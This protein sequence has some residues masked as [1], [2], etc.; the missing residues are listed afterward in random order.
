MQLAP[1]AG[2]SRRLHGQSPRRGQHF[3]GADLAAGGQSDDAVPGAGESA[4]KRGAV[5]AARA[6]IAVAAVAVAVFGLWLAIAVG[7]A[8]AAPMAATTTIAP[9][10]PAVTRA[11]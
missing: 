8:G 11:P 6:G 2:H 9:P 3:V 1:R 5:M 4:E 7:R 10:P